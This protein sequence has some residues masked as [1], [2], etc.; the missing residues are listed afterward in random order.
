MNE[1]LE[2]ADLFV[3]PSLQEGLPVALMEAIANGK[4]CICSRIR[5]NTDLIKDEEYL[6]EPGDIER[7]RKMLE[8]Q[9]TTENSGDTNR[10]MMNFSTERV[11]EAM[12]VIYKAV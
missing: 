8:R 3:F 4:T 9:M 12:T 7:L 5:G 10:K 2:A 11:K 6:F 1:L